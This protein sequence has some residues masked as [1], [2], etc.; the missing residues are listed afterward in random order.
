MTKCRSCSFL[1][2]NLQAKHFAADDCYEMGVEAFTTDEFP[3]AVSWMREALRKKEWDYDYTLTSKETILEYLALSEKKQ[4]RLS[5]V[6]F[7][8]EVYFDHVILD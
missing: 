3:Y 4:G 7:L 5:P 6:Y 1:H 2:N 8:T